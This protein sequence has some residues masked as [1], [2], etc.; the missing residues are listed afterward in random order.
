MGTPSDLETLER[1]NVRKSKACLFLSSTTDPAM[2]D[3]NTLTAGLVEKNWPEVV[4]ILACSRSETVK[5]L[6][7][8]NID[9]GLSATDL[10]MGL[11]VQE[12]EDPGLFAVYSQ[13]STNS[14]GSQIYISKTTVG[15]WVPGDRKISFGKLKQVILRL[16]LP[17]ELLGVKRK[18]DS[19]VLLNPS[20]DLILHPTDRLIYM[21]AGRFNWLER[22]SDILAEIN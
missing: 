1:A 4:T 16:D 18:D 19:N 17:P 3:T 10:K 9:S 2:D 14:G 20:R 7:M 12:L 8:F 22:R 21:A 6:N 5:N 13:L 11:L 15:E